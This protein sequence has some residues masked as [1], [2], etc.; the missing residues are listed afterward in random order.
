VAESKESICHKAQ[1]NQP[2]AVDAVQSEAS[3]RVESFRRRSIATVRSPNDCGGGGGGGGCG[4]GGA[5]GVDPAGQGDA[6]RLPRHRQGACV[7]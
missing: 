6:G 2:S 7:S 1:V 3:P 4:G 5:G